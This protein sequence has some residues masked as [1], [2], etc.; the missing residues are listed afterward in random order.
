[1]EWLR[2][3]WNGYVTEQ[4]ALYGTPFVENS[5]PLCSNASI[6]SQSNLARLRYSSSQVITSGTKIFV[7]I[8]SSD[9]SIS[10]E[11]DTCSNG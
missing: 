11:I 3:S 4:N 5:H 7:M 9:T 6:V 1:M 8:T 2:N 10:Q